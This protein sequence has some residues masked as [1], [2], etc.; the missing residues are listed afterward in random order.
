MKKFKYLLSWIFILIL[1][2]TS[3]IA[4]PFQESDTGSLSISFPKESYFDIDET[5]DFHIHVFNSSGHLLLN[6]EA[7]CLLHIY[8]TT[9]N[10]IVQANMSKDSNN[11]DL[12]YEINKSFFNCVGEY[13]F[14]TSC[15]S[16]N[17][18]GFTSGS[19]IGLKGGYKSSP[20]SNNLISII[21]IGIF[22]FVLIILSMQFKSTTKN[23]RGEDVTNSV[24]QLIKTSIIFYVVFTLQTLGSVV[25]QSSL[26]TNFSNA[27][28]SFFKST[29]LFMRIFAIGLFF[30]VIY[31]AVEYIRQLRKKKQ[32]GNYGR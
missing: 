23:K 28:L 24:G 19:A 17:E 9:G 4:Q 21:G 30:Y 8:N 26:S 29:I 6:N 16:S 14:I 12:Y 27:T 18:G 1:I 20:N 13:T 22:C 25:M 15:N 2:S 3:V 5:F 10:H 31:K 32:M 7:D 11:I